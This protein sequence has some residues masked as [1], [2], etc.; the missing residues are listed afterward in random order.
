MSGEHYYD[1]LGNPCHTQVCGPKAKNPTRPTHIG[2]A[3]KQHLL[4][5]VSG[6]TKM[7]AAGGL[8]SYKLYQVASCCYDSPAHPGED[9]EAY[10]KSMVAKSKEDAA[11]AADVG[12]LVHKALEQAVTGFGYNKDE[13]VVLADGR[14]VYMGSMVE[15][16]LAKMRDLKVNVEAAE[17]VLVNLWDGYAGTTDIIFSGE[18]YGILDFKTRR[19]KA[20]E[21]VK[22]IDTHPMQIAAYIAA[23]WKTAKDVH[24][25]GDLTVGYNLYIS[26]TEPGRIEAIRYNRQ[27]LEESWLDFQACA[28]LWRSLNSYDPRTF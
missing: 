8:E 10:I 2:D 28:R 27:Q 7:L 1:K 18:T 23:H 15:P 17:Q 25:F 13:E 9:K 19:T 20:G 12:T 16:A 11:G 24:P 26:T 6:I 5:S 21:E 3:R 22:P 4:P 14:V